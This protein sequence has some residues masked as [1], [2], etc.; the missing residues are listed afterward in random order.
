M[1]Y[2][3]KR[4]KRDFDSNPIP[5]YYDQNLDS[6]EVNY[7]LA[8]AASFHKLGSIVQ[9]MW[10]GSANITKSLTEECIGFSIKNDGTGDVTITINTFTFV[11][12]TKESF[13]A[14]FMPFTSVIITTTS[15]YRAY[16]TR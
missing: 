15:A 12:K 3:T 11:V 16:V 13:E 10:S 6:Y 2:N 5:Q 8:G 14:N 7:G 9:D 1:P 4:I